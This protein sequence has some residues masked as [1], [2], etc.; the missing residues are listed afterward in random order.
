MNM[1]SKL[2]LFLLI[3]HFSWGQND[4]S[5]IK[6][7]YAGAGITFISASI[8]NHYTDKPTL[9]TWGGIT[10]G[11]LAGL[12][13]EYIYDKAMKKG[14]FSKDDYLMTFWGA[15][16]GGVVIRCTIDFRSRGLQP[17][18]NKDKYKLD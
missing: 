14:V 15:A 2:S 10:I 1:K 16:C 8:I 4:P 7:F 9:S 11:C 13:K 17:R 18:R 6:H 12:G 3:A 5:Q